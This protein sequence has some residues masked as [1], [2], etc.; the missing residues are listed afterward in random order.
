MNSGDTKLRIFFMIKGIFSLGIFAG[1]PREKPPIG[2]T[3]N[4]G[5]PAG[6]GKYPVF[7]KAG[8]LLFNSNK[9]ALLLQ[10]ITIA[11]LPLL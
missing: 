3:W 4:E 7:L 2:D 1:T 5:W 11:D 6:L 9:C 10:F 8:D